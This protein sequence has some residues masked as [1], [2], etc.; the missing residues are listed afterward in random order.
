MRLATFAALALALTPIGGRAATPAS[1]RHAIVVAD[2]PDAAAAGVNVLR[3]GGT[4]ADAA[5]AVQAVLGLEEPQSSGLGGGAFLVYYDARTGRTIAYNGRETAPAAATP[6]L[7]IGPDGKPLDFFTAVT[8]GRST[9]VPAAVS[10]LALAQREH[11]RLAWKDLFADGE[12]LADQ[13]F[14]VPPRMGAMINL[15]FLPQPKT[16]DATAYFSKPGGGRFQAG[17][18]MRNPAYAATLR[19]L[20]AEGSRALYSGAIAGD[21]I[22]KVHSPPLPGALSLD[23]L[24]AYRPEEAPALC[25]PYRSFRIC[26]APPPAGGIGVLELMGL[27]EHTDIAKEGPAGAKAWATFAQASR[28][29]YADRDYYVA[30]PDFVR[31]PTEGLLDPAYE[32]R[33]AA[34]IPAMAPPSPGHPKGAMPHGA[35][36]TEEP[37]GTTHF[38]IVD[39]FGDVASMTTTVESIFGSGRM[40][41]GFFLNN[42]LTDF[43][44]D[45]RDASGALAANAPGPRKRPRSAM[46]PVIVFDSQGRFVAAVGSPG[47]PAIIAYVAKALVGWL[48]WR[49]SLQQA[50][51]LPNIVGHGPVVTVEKDT[52]PT[53]LAGLQAAGLPTRPARFEN[54][55]L[56]GVERTAAGYLGAEDPR[57]E[58][59]ARGY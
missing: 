57:R 26:T 4:A 42:Q 34:L 44:R 15:G 24:A 39:A 12:R 2:E 32:T 43:S 35:D 31:V 7:F 41:D 56:V 27:L 52:D 45:P 20:A 37:G 51:A 50:L 33:R 28:L 6:D 55:G 21:I 11:G 48:D 17:D 49:L 38:V 5:V 8:S 23:D 47:G 30:D 3:A 46:S 22:S 1:F 9:G 14:V 10:M 25:R 29:M 16:P 13:G 58:A 54:S 19:A 59:A 18:V 40:A 36:R 53:I